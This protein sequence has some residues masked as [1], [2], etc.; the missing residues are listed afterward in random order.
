MFEDLSH[1]PPSPGGTAAEPTT[2]ALAK[3]HSCRWRSTPEAGRSDYCTHRD[4]L[5]LAGM[6]GFNA[7]AWCPDCV[8]FK[9]RRSARKRDF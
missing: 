4:V 2:P 3:F 7:E 5:P 8:F 6:T 1:F 9:L